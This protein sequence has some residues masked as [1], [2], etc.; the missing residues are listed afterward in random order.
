MSKAFKIVLVSFLTLI[1]VLVIIVSVNARRNVKSMYSCTNSAIKAL[2]KEYKLKEVRL[3]KYKTLKL[4]GIMKFNVKQY[5]IEDIGN[6]SVMHMNVGLMQMA[7]F[8]ITPKDKNLPLV[9]ADYMYILSNRKCYLEFYDVIK[10]KDEQYKNLLDSLKD[11]L[12]NYKHLEDINV[13][14]AWYK[15]L[16]TVTS[17][18]IGKPSDDKELEK[19]LTECIATYAK[20]S[21]NFDKLS[22]KEKKEKIAITTEYTDG[23]IKKGGISTDVFK[24]QLG[25]ETT[26]DFFD[27]VFFGTKH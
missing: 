16:L 23:L 22:K 27:T 4:Y 15:D 13:S 21:K 20:E 2:Q 26:K 1:L 18:K 7:T 9:S 17:Y 6:L 19:L 24:D 14:D 5:E 8:V 12:N 3:D 25:N 11:V 10:E